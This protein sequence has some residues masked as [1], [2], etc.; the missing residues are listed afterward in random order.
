MEQS[1]A[2]YWRATICLPSRLGNPGCFSGCLAQGLLSSFLASNG[3]SI[4]GGG[5]APEALID[6]TQPLLPPG[7]V[8]GVHQFGMGLASSDLLKLLSNVHEG[9]WLVGPCSSQAVWRR[10]RHQ[11]WHLGSQLQAEP[12]ASPTIVC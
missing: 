9:I 8:C 10:A 1:R 4:V 7:Q 11:G 6:T 12:C 3:L 5:L 2:M